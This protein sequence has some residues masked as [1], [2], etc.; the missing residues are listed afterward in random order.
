MTEADLG[1][2]LHRAADELDALG[3]VADLVAADAPPGDVFD[4]VVA[5]AAELTGVD[6]IT[7]LRFENG[8]GTEIVA[9]T[10]NPASLEVGMRE[11]GDGVGATQQVLRTGRTA[12]IDDLSEASV[13]AVNTFLQQNRKEN[14]PLEENIQALLALRG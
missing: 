8:G 7:L 13:P 9:M 11:P 4:E 10:G 1:G 2:N 12:R 6:F 3:R 14:A 5:Q